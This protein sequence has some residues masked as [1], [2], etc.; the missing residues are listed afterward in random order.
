MSFSE[1][2]AGTRSRLIPASIPFSFFGAALVFQVA[3]WGLLA[4]MADRVPGFTGGLGPVLAALHLVALGVLLMTAMGAALQVLPMVTRRPLR[5]RRTA[6]ALFWVYCPGVVL[7]THGMGAGSVAAMEGGGGLCVAAILLFLWLGA[8]NIC[9]MRHLELVTDNLSLAFFCLLSLALAGGALVA[10]F[11]FGFM[12]DHA[13]FS[14]AHAVIATYGFM[15]LLALGSSLL[16]VPL[17]GVPAPSDDGAGRLAVLIIAAALLLAAAG[18]LSGI[19]WVVVLSAPIG[20]AGTALHLWVMR[21]AMTSRVRPG[22]RVAFLLVRVGW[23]C[24]P[25]S[26]ALGLL[27]LFGAADGPLPALFGFVLIFGW[28]LSFL[29]GILQRIMPFLAAMHAPKQGD[30]IGLADSL[31]ASAPLRL[32]A[33]AH[34]AALLL[35]GTGIALQSVALV[36]GGAVCGAAG[37][38][39]FLWFA[40]L[41]GWRWR[42]R[43]RKTAAAVNDSLGSS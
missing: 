16:L 35:A 27:A 1:A 13:A 41:L 15:G 21:R 18:G 7:L 24:L 43:W 34:V 26:I 14:L 12:P 9:R 20:L 38:L 8:D 6:R 30:P 39:A 17:F 36:R 32:H 3:A 5:S 2:M 22:L 29:T 37:G 25:L 33:W 40:A 23:G 4:L 31:T 10:D 28:L 11:D 42:W 19:F